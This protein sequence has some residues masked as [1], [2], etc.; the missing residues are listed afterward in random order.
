[1][2]GVG[3]GKRGCGGSVGVNFSTGRALSGVEVPR[4]FST[5]FCKDQKKVEQRKI[6]AVENFLKNFKHAKKS[7]D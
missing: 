7:G 3:E 4:H 1:M 6:S 5:F 2:G